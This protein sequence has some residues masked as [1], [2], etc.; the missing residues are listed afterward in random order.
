M[1]LSPKS[2]LVA[3]IFVVLIVGY[4]YYL[5]NRSDTSAEASTGLTE[6]QKITT[7][8]LEQSYPETPREV[9]KFY[10]RIVMCYY[11]EEYTE[12]EL[13]QMVDQARMLFDE[14]LLL[15]NP[16]D[17]YLKSVKED[18]ASYQ[19]DGKTLSNVTI[20]DSKDVKKETI[21]G[22]DYAYVDCTYYIREGSSFAVVSQTYMLRKDADG[23]WKLLAFFQGGNPSEA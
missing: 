12:E 3:V 2:L 20:S 11:N 17:E 16:R 15:N 4:Y 21:A 1:K 8:N 14:E 22:R 13:A 6:V 23:R 18:V 9:I 5:S 7:E 19:R 10:N